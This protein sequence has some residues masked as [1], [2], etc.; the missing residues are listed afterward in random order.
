MGKTVL[1]IVEHKHGKLRQ[2]ALESLTVA[3]QIA[4]DGGRVISGVIG[5]DVAQVA[6]ELSNYPHNGGYVVADE[7]LGTYNPDLYAAA[8]NAL[9]EQVKPDVVV[10]GHTAIGRDI[11]PIIAA[12]LEAGQVSDI[13]GLVTDDDGS[14]SF[15]RPIYAGKA[16]ERRQFLTGPW[17]VTVRPN[18]FPA[19]TRGETEQIEFTP[20]AF[21]PPASERFVVRETVQ[22]SDGKRDL[23][24]ASV[25]VSGGRGVK[26][27]DG[28]RPLEELANVLDGAVG[29]SRAACDAGYCDYSLQIGQTGKVVTPDVYIACGISGAIQHLAGMSQSKLI[30]AINKDEEAPIFGIADY[31]VVGDLFEIVPKLTEE[32]KRRKIG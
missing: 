8:V 27:A 23:T 5:D 12:D 1:V 31:G 25:V 30:I 21:T 7:R 6:S 16:F 32:L 9:V 19:I 22:A 29:A 2:V 3:G 24:E 18:N 13:V 28:F 11:A 15:I 10:F 20:L 17:I 14:I 4:G 26:S